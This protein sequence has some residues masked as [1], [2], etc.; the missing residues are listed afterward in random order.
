[1][2][3]LEILVVQLFNPNRSRLFQFLHAHSASTSSSEDDRSYL[4]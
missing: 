1:L 3:Y 2:R 4:S